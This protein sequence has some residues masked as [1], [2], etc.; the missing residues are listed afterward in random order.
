[1]KAVNNRTGNTLKQAINDCLKLKQKKSNTKI[2]EQSISN[3]KPRRSRNLNDNRRKD[4]IHNQRTR[5]GNKCFN[6]K[7]SAQVNKKFRNHLMQMKLANYGKENI[8]LLDKIIYVNSTVVNRVSMHH[9]QNSFNEPR[10][11]LR[12][13]KSNREKQKRNIY[14]WRN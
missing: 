7:R 11:N 2:W 10:L 1:M 12:I 9:E 4:R 14:S 8:F 13:K 6:E 3:R 5:L